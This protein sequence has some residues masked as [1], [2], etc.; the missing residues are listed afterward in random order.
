[1]AKSSFTVI[2][3]GGSIAGLTLAHGLQRAGID[4]VVLEKHNE[5]AA[6]A[7]AGLSILP[8]GA[9]ILDQL[10]LWHQIEKVSGP[11]LRAQLCF[12]D[13]FAFSSDLPA[14]LQKQSDPSSW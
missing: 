1:M 8:H 11:V 4:Y 5:I 12:P 3:V 13:G 2:I 14:M 10:Q 6:S 7:G 9:Q